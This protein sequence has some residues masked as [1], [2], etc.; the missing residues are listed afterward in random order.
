VTKKRR[1]R[2]KS[3]TSKKKSTKFSSNPSG[4]RPSFSFVDTKFNK[5]RYKMNEQLKNRIQAYQNLNFQQ[6]RNENGAN[7][8]SV[9][10]DKD[11]RF[12]VF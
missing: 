6:M 1:K 8:K 5:F 11:S 4:T 2:P 12:I 3:L 9:Q 10:D 7:L